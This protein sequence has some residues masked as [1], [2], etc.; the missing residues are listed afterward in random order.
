[1][2][3]MTNFAPM[4]ILYDFCMVKSE[5]SKPPTTDVSTFLIPIK[6]HTILLVLLQ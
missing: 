1:M 3:P 6:I 2:V 4:I 5:I